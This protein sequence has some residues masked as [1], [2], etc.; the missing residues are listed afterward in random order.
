MFTNQLPGSD[1]E[2]KMQKAFETEEKA[3]NFY[4]T[5]MLDYLAEDMQKFIQSQEMVFIATADK[6]G[7]CDNSFRS[8]EKGFVKIINEKYLAY[9][10]FKGN[11]VLASLGNVTENPHIGMLFIDFFE[12]K[13]GLHV[14][15]KVKM[16]T[17]DAL[18]TFVQEKNANVELNTSMQ[19]VSFWMLVEVEEAYIHCSRNIPLFV[20]NND[21]TELNKTRVVDF[22]NLQ[23]S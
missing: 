7:E 14:N 1:G 3:K 4:K 6:N 8:G 23:K 12:N 22:F 10:D 9:P 16:L 20:K 2:H 5:Q 15:G 11:G 18:T 17:E 21:E 19:K 13:V